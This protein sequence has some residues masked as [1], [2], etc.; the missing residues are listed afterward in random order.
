MLLTGHA[1]RA[2]DQSNSQ[3]ILRYERIFSHHPGQMMSVGWDVAESIKI[4]SMFGIPQW[5]PR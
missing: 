4:I 3:N 5:K 1:K 2:V